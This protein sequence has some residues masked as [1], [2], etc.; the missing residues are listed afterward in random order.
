MQWKA[1]LSQTRRS[2]SDQLWK[3]ATVIDPPGRPIHRSFRNYA[4][5]LSSPPL[6]TPLP[7]SHFSSLHRNAGIRGVRVSQCLWLSLWIAKTKRE[8]ERGGGKMAET[9]MNQRMN[10]CVIDA[11]WKMDRKNIQLSNVFDVNAWRIESAE[12][13]GSWLLYFQLENEL[14]KL[15]GKY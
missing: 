15:Y 5:L 14:G 10:I 1:N 3:I 9:E 4:N 8:R 12:G 13:V 11:A 2:G 6:S 7:R